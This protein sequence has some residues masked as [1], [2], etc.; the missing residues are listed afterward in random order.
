MSNGDKLDLHPSG[1][2]IR[3]EHNERKLS[4][5][6]DPGIGPLIERLKT[7]EA[8]DLIGFHRVLPQDDE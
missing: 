5:T 2:P 3:K 4:I 7:P 8:K 1:R 6:R